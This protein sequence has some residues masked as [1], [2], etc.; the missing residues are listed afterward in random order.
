MNA[1]P[2]LRIHEAERSLAWWARLGF[3]EEFRHQFEAG[4]PLY[5]GIKRGDSVI[6]LS[7]HD[8]DAPGPALLYLWVD[9]VD[10]VAVEFGVEV[11]EMPWAR[12]CEVTDPDGNRVRVATATQG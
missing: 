12:D 8:G 1:I 7:Q 10:A 11:Q 3:T 2:I 6:H 9:D 4:F 5:L